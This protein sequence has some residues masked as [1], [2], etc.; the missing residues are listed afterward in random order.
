MSLRSAAA[1][2][3]PGHPARGRAVAGAP[4]PATR[5]RRRAPPG[6][7]TRCSRAW[8]TAATTS[9]TTT[10]A[11]R[12]ETARAG[13]GRSTGPSASWPAR[14]RR[15]RASISTSRARASAT[16][17]STAA[18]ATWTRD[19]EELVVT[20]PRPLREGQVFSTRV[21]H[22]TATP[23]HRRPRRRRDRRVLLDAGRLGH[24]AA[25][26]PRPPPVPV[27]RPPARQGAL[28]VHASTC[29]QGTTAVANGVFTGRDAH[30]GRWVWHYRQRQPMATELTQIAVGRFTITERGVTGRRRRA[31]RDAAPG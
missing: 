24:G 14:R 11:L 6:S 25:A 8:A 30:D 23:T 9:C 22:F 18:A 5:R 1:C 2:R 16:S 21:R 3:R 26:G 12:Y 27:E 4:R 20:P 13:A 19:G 7:A 15:C 17:S 29:R 31:R 10:S 28:H